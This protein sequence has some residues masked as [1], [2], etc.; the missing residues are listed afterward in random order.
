MQEGW[1]C[2][3]C[4]RINAP[5]VN[6]CG[7]KADDKQDKSEEIAKTLKENK[8]LEKILDDI[9]TTIPER[10]GIF[11]DKSDAE[12][13]YNLAQGSKQISRLTEGSNPISRLSQR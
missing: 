1:L 13:L 10:N 2:P 7:C 4:G 5:F 8:V 6:Y 3:R 12:T 11:I 9:S